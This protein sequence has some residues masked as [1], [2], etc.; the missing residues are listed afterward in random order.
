MRTRGGGALILVNLTCD[1]VACTV[2]LKAW[3]TSNDQLQE[4]GGNTSR[5]SVPNI[6][7]HRKKERKSRMLCLARVLSPHSL[8]PRKQIGGLNA[9]LLSSPRPHLFAATTIL[10]PH[11]RVDAS[12]ETLA[13]PLFAETNDAPEP[14]HTLLS[15]SAWTATTT[16]PDTLVS[17]MLQLFSRHASWAAQACTHSRRGWCR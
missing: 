2:Q 14:P 1:G 9:S 6:P 15:G 7:G 16:S 13:I 17:Q 11:S 10:L 8:T 3:R 4:S 5:A 12:S